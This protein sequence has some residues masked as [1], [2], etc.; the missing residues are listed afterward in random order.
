LR[1]RVRES[2]FDA[3][4]PP[5][6][7]WYWKGDFVAQIPDEAIDEHLKFAALRNPLGLSKGCCFPLKQ[8]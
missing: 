7:Q 2:T 8:S 1:R 5:A 6:D 3:I 4:Y